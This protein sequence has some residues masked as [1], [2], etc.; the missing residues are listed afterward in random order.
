MKKL[1]E[2]NKPQDVDAWEEEIKDIA[3]FSQP[4]EKPTAPLILTEVEKTPSHNGLYNPNSFTQLKV[5]N[6]DNLDGATATRFRKG[7]LKIEAR[8]DLHGRTEKEA[9]AAVEDFIHNAYAQ[10][11]R[12]V[13]IITGKGIRQENDPWYETKGIIKEALPAWL[14]HAEIRPFILSMC[15]AKP[16]DGG[17]GAMYVLLKRQRRLQNSKI[18]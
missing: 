9:F 11:K 13:L 3:P 1:P 18:F 2:G 4:E 7:D 16:E 10:N 17:S 5:G 14:N 6:T 8:L 12:C 15:Q